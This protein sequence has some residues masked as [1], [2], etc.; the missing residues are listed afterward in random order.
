MYRSGIFLTLL[1]CC[2]I[3]SPSASAFY[4][5]SSFEERKQDYLGNPGTNLM[6]AVWAWLETGSNPAGVTAAIDYITG[7]G[8]ATGAFPGPNEVGRMYYQYKHKL[9]SADI[10]KIEFRLNEVANVTP[11][12][13]GTSHFGLV[14][15]CQLVL[16]A[17][18]WS[19][20]LQYA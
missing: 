5:G 17:A 7:P 3:L 14:R 8:W 4:Q 1:L 10:A 9:S 12:R 15:Q 18:R 19:I 11:P 16:A 2:F 6:Q 20:S 13:H